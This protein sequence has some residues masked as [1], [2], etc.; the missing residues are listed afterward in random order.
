MSPL[1]ANAAGV[2][3]RL[4]LDGGT[5]QKRHT[6]SEDSSYSCTQAPSTLG[7]CCQRFICRQLKAK[8]ASD[9]SFRSLHLLLPLR[10]FGLAGVLVGMGVL[11]GC[12]A[13]C[14]SAPS[15]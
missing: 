14:C 3:L 2:A 11:A 15:L 8:L 7:L 5:L 12:A 1:P 4:L 10:R 13:L 9:H 6:V